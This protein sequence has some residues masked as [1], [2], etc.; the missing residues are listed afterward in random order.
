MSERLLLV[1][2]EEDI[3][4]FLGM[5]LADLGYEVHAAENGAQA[6]EMFDAV[7]PS[8]VL[9][10]IKMP[11][12]DGLELLKQIKA[13]SP[14]TEVVMISGHGDMDLAIGCLQYDA[15][16]FVTKPI[17][18]DILDA[19]LKRV[20]E[21]IILRRELKQYTQNLEKLV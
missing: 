4:R 5:F 2:D 15:A 11:V 10:D 16:D 3:R 1:D 13:K 21:K 17:N 7:N 8:I 20:E 6:L 12:M 14:E 19:A 9:T 18:H